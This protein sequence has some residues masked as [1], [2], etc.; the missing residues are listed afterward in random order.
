[1]KKS[2]MR[3]IGFAA[4]VALLCVGM[5]C[6]GN[7]KSTD[8]DGQV[9]GFLGR[10]NEE[11]GAGTEPGTYAYKLTVESIGEGATVSGYNYVVGQ[12]V[13]INAGTSPKP[14]RWPFENWTST[15]KGVTFADADSAS[16]SFTMP[17]NDVT[18]TANFLDL[19]VLGTFTDKRNNTKYKTTN[20]GVLGKTWMAENLNYEVDSSWCYDNDNL[21]CTK[22]G[23]LYQWSAAMNINA[24]YNSSLWNGSDVN[25]QGVCPD[26]WHLPSYDEMEALIN[27]VK[28]RKDLMAT[29]GWNSYEC[30]YGTCDGNG[31]DVFGFSALPSGRR[32]SDGSFVSAGNMGYWW[33][34]TGTGEEEGIENGAAAALMGIEG[35]FYWLTYISDRGNALSVR[36]VGD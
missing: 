25:R 33:T 13:F 18:V 9:D 7:G 31:T 12:T 4:T 34:A 28:N 3:A 17:A 16:T 1:M 26:G 10:V 36:C 20:M 14:A 30:A 11:P 29:N 15:S 8:W 21:N 5:G 35:F 32:N 24:S 27:A 6:D 22:Y 2:I 19:L 23:R